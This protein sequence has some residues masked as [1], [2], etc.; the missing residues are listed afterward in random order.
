MSNINN[1][2][3]YIELPLLKKAETQQFYK[4]VFGWEFT[5][6]GPNYIGFSKAG[7]NGGFNGESGVQPTAPGVLLVLYVRDLDKTLDKITQAG[8]KIVQAIYEFPGGRRFHFQDP[9][10]N[11]LAVWSE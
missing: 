8:G 3:N 4:Q 10:G 7:I 6:W 9:N 5:D 1:T 11:E 2:I